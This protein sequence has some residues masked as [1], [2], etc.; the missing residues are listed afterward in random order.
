[1]A[2]FYFFLLRR[3][4]PSH[5]GILGVT[6]ALLLIAGFM[7][8]CGTSSTAPQVACSRAISQQESDAVSQG[9]QLTK[10]P[11]SGEY[12]MP[13]ILAV[14]L[15][16]SD[17]NSLTP[18]LAP[19]VIKQIQLIPGINS[20]TTLTEYVSSDDDAGEPSFVA[21]P[22][23][24]ASSATLYLS[25]TS[26][27]PNAL[28]SVI[29]AINKS[30]VAILPNLL[31]VSGTPD[32]I[33]GASPDWMLAGGLHG[34]DLI[35]GSPDGPPDGYCT[36]SSSVF[37]TSAPSGGD[38][39]VLDSVFNGQSVLKGKTSPQS[40]SSL[41]GS[42]CSTP[43]DPCAAYRSL[44]AHL[45]DV[46]FWP[47]DEKLGDQNLPSGDYS[48]H[49]IFDS[50]LVHYFAP[51][52]AIHLI[53]VLD[54]HNAG[55]LPD[56]QQGL[57]AALAAILNQPDGSKVVNL[58]LTAG[59]PLDCLAGLWA[60]SNYTETYSNSSSSD[61]SLPQSD[62]V[63]G[64]GESLSQTLQLMYTTVVLPIDA[65]L[66]QGSNVQ[67]VAASGNDGKDYDA[68]MPAALCRVQA[69]TAGYYAQ[70]RIELQRAPFANNP[71]IGPLA[72]TPALGQCLQMSLPAANQLSLGLKS[73]STAS[74][75]LGVDVCS[76]YNPSEFAYWSGT[77]FA[78]AMH[79]G[80]DANGTPFNYQTVMLQLHEL[81]GMPC[82]P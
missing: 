32:Y 74:G 23:G 19:S 11:I 80:R 40:L 54:D 52:A 64:S 76:L 59:P 18:A 17:P 55:M 66:A 62:C 3:S 69:V 67:V 50:E 78:A 2:H 71:Y 58:S 22:A 15:V 16:S 6:L 56:L 4:R 75:D 41:Y 10:G 61:P 5:R 24:A 9:G 47:L 39:Y 34:G 7:A 31:P 27:D 77:S 30:I 72:G 63:P 73:N 21:V 33:A 8:G 53:R 42:H 36:T 81:G 38:V 45:P 28:V 43:R 48:A 82:T 1:M 49:G 25:V 44:A 68:D 79:S 60:D 14:E 35:G 29:N 13:N 26:S 12:W 51:N 70:G 57:R 37:G 46:T 65:L 20:S